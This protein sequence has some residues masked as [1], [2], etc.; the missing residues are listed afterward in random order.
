M[1]DPEIEKSLTAILQKVRSFLK[2]KKCGNIEINMFMGGITAINT[3]QS[4]KPPFI[5]DDAA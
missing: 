4:E 2:E 3:K 1:K 5:A